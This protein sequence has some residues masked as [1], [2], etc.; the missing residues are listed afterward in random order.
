MAVG[1]AS[2]FGQSQLAKFALSQRFA[3]H[4]S[5]Q[6]INMHVHLPIR[7]PDLQVGAKIM[8]SVG[9]VVGRAGGGRRS[10]GARRGGPVCVCV[11]EREN[12]ASI[13]SAGPRRALGGAPGR[14]AAPRAAPL[15]PY[16]R[17][18][19]C[20]LAIL[21]VDSRQLKLTLDFLGLVRGPESAKKL[22]PPEERIDPS[23][24]R[25]H[26]GAG[27]Q[28]RRSNQLAR[29]RAHSRV[30]LLLFEKLSAHFGHLN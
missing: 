15:A 17:R 5:C 12:G 2:K 22:A 9:V 19:L 13:I 1:A 24:G 6:S 14:Q 20:S 4:T 8:M 16:W 28:G 3:I 26:K 27:R 23:G 30:G 29:L 25:P 10:V 11:R 21:N 18:P 7:R